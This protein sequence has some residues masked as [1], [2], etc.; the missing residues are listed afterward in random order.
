MRLRGRVLEKQ[1]GAS[2][3]W[4]VEM[5]MGYPSGGVR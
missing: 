5:Y 2:L 4:V 1:A 3:Q